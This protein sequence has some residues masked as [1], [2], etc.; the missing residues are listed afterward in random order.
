MYTERASCWFFK[1]V[2]PALRPG[3]SVHTVVFA[4]VIV[5]AGS[6]SFER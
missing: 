4:M 1:V 6:W 5:E 2:T 3:Q